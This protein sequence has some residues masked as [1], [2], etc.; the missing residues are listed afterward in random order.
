MSEGDKRAI[1]SRGN[2]LATI[3]EIPARKIALVQLAD[4]PDIAMDV[5]QLSRHDR[6]FP[7]RG[8]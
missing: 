8:A 6:C 4:A 3:G 5:L 7:G 1:F 2:S